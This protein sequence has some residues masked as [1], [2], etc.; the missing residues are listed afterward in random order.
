[1]IGSTID[2]GILMERVFDVVRAVASIGKAVII[3]R[4]GSE[5]TRDMPFGLSIRLVAP[6]EKRVEHLM[7]LED[8]SARKAAAEVRRRDEHRARLLDTHFGVD[9]A[10]PSRYDVTW[11]TGSCPVDE[12]AQS[13]VTLLTHRVKAV[14]QAAQ[15]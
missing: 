3:G 1:M 6:I 10:D 11:N 12:I 9:I 13:T 2:H 5:V 8:L 15:A 4:G 7:R 14:E